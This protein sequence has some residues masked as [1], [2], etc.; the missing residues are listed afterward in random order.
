MMRSWRRKEI[1]RIIEKI[2]ICINYANIEE[3]TIEEDIINK[4][5]NINAQI[6]E[7]TIKEIKIREKWKKKK[8][9]IQEY[10]ENF[11]NNLINI[12]KNKCQKILMNLL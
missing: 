10:K 3:N 12:N 7:F 5:E 8:E 6:A 4:F 11:I 9:E 1:S 2:C